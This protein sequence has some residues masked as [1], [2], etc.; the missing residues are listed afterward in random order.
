[1][2][3]VGRWIQSYN[4]GRLA[5][6]P[7][8]ALSLS[9]SG[10][11]RFNNKGGGATCPMFEKDLFA[12]V[13]MYRILGVMVNNK[14]VSEIAQALRDEDSGYREALVHLQG[15]HG[16]DG[17]TYKKGDPLNLNPAWAAKWSKRF[18]TAYVKATKRKRWCASSLCC[19]FFL[20]C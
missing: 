11:P 6:P 19:A 20:L 17:R 7:V 4:E 18:N 9:G 2:L 15:R 5:P 10:R 13:V 14:V 16:A 8:Q 3:S 1:M 12:R